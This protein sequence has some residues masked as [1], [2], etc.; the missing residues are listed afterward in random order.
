MSADVTA[1]I[2]ALQQNTIVSYID[3]CS[4]ALLVFDWSLTLDSEI[5][6]IWDSPWNLGRILF[7]LTRYPPFIN[8][9]LAIFYRMVYSLPASTCSTI[10]DVRS[11]IAIFGIIVAEVILTLRVWILWDR[12]RK[13]GLAVLLASFLTGAAGVV[14]YVL[15]AGGYTF[16][17]TQSLSPN[18]SGC[19]FIKGHIALLWTLVALM[20][21]Q[22][23]IFT[24][25]VV[26]CIRNFRLRSY[27]TSLLR[28]FYL[29]GVIYY[30]AQQ[31]LS[32]VNLVVIITTHSSHMVNIMTY[33][34]GV[35]LS[36][37]SARMILHLHEG[38][39]AR[40]DILLDEE[41]GVYHFRV[42]K[43]PLWS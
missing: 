17:A 43:R 3:V 1:T 27:G 34:Q 8:V 42:P 22:T 25:T 40:N 19:F 29:D 20:I 13:V 35:L 26:H 10:S 36:I 31:A 18:I 14:D 39:R 12:S 38:T 11:W 6:F 9:A 37:L 4:V 23:F 7:F 32:V 21:H 15:F 30:L 2:I 41:P 28:T 24:L 33:I 5:K 16:V